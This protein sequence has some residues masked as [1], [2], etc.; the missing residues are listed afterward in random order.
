M[1]AEKVASSDT[2]V[3]HHQTPTGRRC[4]T[5]SMPASSGL[6]TTGPQ[7]RTVVTI[8]VDDTDSDVT[9]EE[10]VAGRT[11]MHLSNCAKSRRLIQTHEK[12]EEHRRTYLVLDVGNLALQFLDPISQFLHLGLVLF[13]PAASVLQ[14]GAAVLQRFLQLHVRVPHLCYVLLKTL[15]VKKALDSV[16]HFKMFGTLF[17]AGIPLPVVD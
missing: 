6:K 12:P 5:H 17:D 2:L 4:K 9:E 15:H 7:Q 13:G 1:H 11:Q 10:S 16:N 14:L 8:S 3:T